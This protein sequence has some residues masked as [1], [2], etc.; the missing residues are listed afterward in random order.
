MSKVTTTLI[1]EANS[2][3]GEPAWG[4][5]VGATSQLNELSAKQRVKPTKTIEAKQQLLAKKLYN[6]MI[7][8]LKEKEFFRYIKM[9]LG[10]LI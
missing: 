6:P 4:T 7:T 8:N 1:S 10:P 3:V 9:K 2:R 5:K